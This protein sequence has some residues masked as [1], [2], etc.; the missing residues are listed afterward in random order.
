MSQEL[1]AENG[2]AS[3]DTVIVE[4]A[5]GSVTGKAVVTIRL[6]PSQVNGTTVHYI[7]LPWN[8]GYMGLSKGDSANRLTPRIGDPNTGIPE[9]RAFLCNVHRA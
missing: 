5:R 3:G 8:W 4:S 9:F 6:K 2:I 7:S 1:A